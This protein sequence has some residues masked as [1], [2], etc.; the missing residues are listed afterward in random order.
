MQIVSQRE[1][2]HEMSKPVFWKKY[3]ET[4]TKTKKKK[5]KKETTKKKTTTTTTNKQTKVVSLS[6]PE[7]AQ[8]VEKVV[9]GL[10]VNRYDGC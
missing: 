9:G 10:S 5:K 2:L 1:N 8:R 3:E 7:F 6:S 4:K